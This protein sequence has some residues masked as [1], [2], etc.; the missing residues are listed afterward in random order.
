M[1]TENM[2][3]LKFSCDLGWKTYSQSFGCSNAISKFNIGEGLENR[4]DGFRPLGGTIF[5]QIF[6]NGFGGVLFLPP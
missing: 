4:N 5:G 1:L 6:L 3:L 2:F